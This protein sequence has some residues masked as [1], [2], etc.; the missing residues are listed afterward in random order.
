[1]MLEAH[2]ALSSTEFENNLFLFFVAGHETT[3]T[4]LT[5]ELLLLA[6]YPEIQAKVVAEVD[7]VLGG[8]HVDS[9]TLKEFNYM[10]M[11]IKEVL[12]YGS[13]VAILPSRKAATDVQLDKYTIPANT[14]VGLA[15]H[16]IHHN[17]EFWPN[18]EVFDPERF[19][20]NRAIKQHPFAFLPFSLGRRVCIGNNFSLM[21]QKVVLSL[22]LQKYTISIA[23]DIG[24]FKPDPEAL[25]NQPG[26]VRIM[27]TRRK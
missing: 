4:A 15:I 20:P 16:A 9:E 1:M 3:S 25:T 8:K 7:K 6:K 14:T 5:W 23:K 26:D 11:F 24:D 27:L 18:P 2:P 19:A 21:E 22:L 13:P 12:R 10:E 17:S